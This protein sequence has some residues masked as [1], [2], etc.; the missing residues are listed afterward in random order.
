[1]APSQQNLLVVLAAGCT[2]DG[3]RS[4]INAESV[5]PQI[6]RLTANTSR[7]DRLQEFDSG[8]SEVRFPKKLEAV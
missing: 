7:L 6:R 4:C 8:P 2:F 3:S 5:R 1:M